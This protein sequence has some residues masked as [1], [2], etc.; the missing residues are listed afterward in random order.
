MEEPKHILDILIEKISKNIDKD[1]K[2]YLAMDDNDKE[3]LAIKTKDQER[4]LD[5]AQI[6][7]SYGFFRI[8]QSDSEDEALDKLSN[9]LIKSINELLEQGASEEK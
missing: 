8:Y 1:I 4:G 3:L 9:N 5:L 2:V 6:V 7:N